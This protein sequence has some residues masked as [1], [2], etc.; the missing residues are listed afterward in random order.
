MS[1]S[2]ILDEARA[3][4]IDASQRRIRAD[5]AK[6]AAKTIKEAGE[7]LHVA[8]DIIGEDRLKGESPF[9]HGS[10]D[11][12]GVSLVLRIAAELVSASTD[13]FADGRQYAAAALLRQLVELEYLAWA[14]ETRHDDAKKWLRSSRVERESFFKPAKLRKAAGGKF[15]GEDYSHHCELG[16]HPVPQGRIL[17][18]HDPVLAELMLSD[19]LGHVGQIW[20]HAGGWARRSALGWPIL[21]R[22]EE[23]A[24]RFS[25]WK[26]RDGLVKLPPP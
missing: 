12:V 11:A 15:R 17:L 3:D 22:S 16:G 13:L 1:M 8:G 14:I 9:G 19:L 23:M 26:A 20:N 21:E 5:L 24:K 25:E 18:R 2:V 4:A 10:D 6:F 7:A